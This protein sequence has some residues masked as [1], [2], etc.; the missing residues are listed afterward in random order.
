MKDTKILAPK[1]THDVLPDESYIWQDIESK[2]MAICRNFGYNEIR[3][4]TFEHTELFNRGVGDTTDV[5]QKEMY[6]FNDKG[7]RSITLRPEGTASTVRSFIENSLYAQALPAKMCYLISCFRYERPQAGRF[8]EF[9]Q[10]GV[11]NF[12]SNSAYTDAEVITL[13]IQLLSSAGV[14]G[15]KLY[16]NSIGCVQCR[17]KYNEVLKN[18]LNS[19]KE[20]LCG[21]CMDRIDRNPLRVLDCKNKDCQE[22]LKDAPTVDSVLCDDC[23]SHFDTLKKALSELGIDYVVDT[24]LVRG[25]DYYTKTV[26]EIKSEDLGAQSTV[27]G[28]GRYDGLIEQL[29]GPSTPGIGFSIGLERLISIVQKQNTVTAEKP[30]PKIYI[31]S[32][33]EEATSIAFKCV[34]AL[35]KNNVSAEFDHLGKSVKAQMKYADKIGAK[36][37]VVI[38]DDEIVQMKAKCKNM[39]TGESFDIDINELAKGNF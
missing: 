20:N 38:G 21:L 29:G 35:R 9:R 28:G 34:T 17:K 25:L 23:V 10:F 7:D 3:F 18:F 14:K 8:R 26:F 11:E 30:V 19:K 16:I 2:M 33:G 39:E 6:T 22:I 24:G 27:C 37:S 12:G 36:F 13:A 32:M 4:P 31:A 15:L 1:G 5:V